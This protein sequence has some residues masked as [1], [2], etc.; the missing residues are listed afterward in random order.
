MNKLD[1]DVRRPG[2]D[3]Q[4][5][6]KTL[7][8]LEPGIFGLQAVLV[9]HD[10]KLFALLADEPRTAADVC[11]ALHLAQRPAEALLALCASVGLVDIQGAR[12]A[13]TPG[14]RAYLVPGKPEYFGDFLDVTIANREAL[15]F[16]S[17]KKAVLTNASQ[18]YAGEELFKSHAE[19][20]ERA[21]AFTLAMHGHSMKHAHVWPDKIDLSSH[22]T[23]LDVGGGS[24]AHSIGAARRWPH[25]QAVI[26]DMAPVCEVACEYVARAGLETRVLT[27]TGDMWQDPF[28]PADLHFYADI[29]HDWPP[30]KC[31]QL[32][33]KSFA[34]LPPGGR[35]VLHETLYN[36]DKIGPFQAA[37]LDI[38]MLLWT[39]G[40]QYTGPELAA[41]L[42]EAGFVDIDVRPTFA[43]SSL[44]SGRKP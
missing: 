15:S 33:L 13:L 32:T 14:A 16:D 20:V 42:A 4:A 41:M 43:H 39:E 34:S 40:R 8:G 27:H 35:I 10:L 37:G 2:T 5:V 6:W 17:V 9:A 12:Y 3:E 11:A 1:V 18:V 22:R 26:F 44:V 31:R 21:R 38:C 24:G 28:P 29:Y 23:L 19:E 30:E 7:E 36:D 25:L